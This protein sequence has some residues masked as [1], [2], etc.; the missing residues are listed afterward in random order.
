VRPL[1]PRPAAQGLFHGVY[2]ARCGNQPASL[3]PV[4]GQDGVYRVRRQRVGQLGPCHAVTLPRPLH[5]RLE[6]VARH[7]GQSYRMLAQNPIQ[8]VIGRDHIEQPVYRRLLEFLAPRRMHSNR[9]TRGKIRRHGAKDSVRPN[10][11]SSLSC[12]L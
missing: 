2:S 8:T 3:P 1:P 7:G 9:P 10:E 5:G 4:G 6:M 12:S 11:Y